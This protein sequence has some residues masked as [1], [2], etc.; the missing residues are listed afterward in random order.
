[1]EDIMEIENTETSTDETSFAVE[2][3]K[4]AAL[5]AATVI[6]TFAGM[7]V[8]STTYNKC[9]EI[10]EAREA[11]KAAKKVAKKKQEVED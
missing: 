6:G 5:G 4:A 11:K 8:V 7:A 1:M 3:A 10:M 9:V 2:L